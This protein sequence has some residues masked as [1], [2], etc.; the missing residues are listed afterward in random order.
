MPITKNQSGQ[1]AKRRNHTVPKCLLK[2]WLTHLDGSSGH[3]TLDCAGNY[4]FFH[5]GKDAEFAIRDYRYVP[6]RSSQD[7]NAY[8]DESLEDW[9]AQ[10]ENDFA[11]VTDRILAGEQIKASEG[12]FGGFLQAAILLGFRSWYEYTIAEQELKSRRPDLSDE[13]RECMIVDGFKKVYSSKLHQFKNWDY[14]LISKLSEPL[15]LCDRPLFDMT[16]SSPPQ[17]CLFIPLA[18]DLLLIGTAPGDSTRDT[19]IFS[20]TTGS[21]MARRANEMTVE[22]AREFIVG[23][24]AQLIALMPKFTPGKF[25]GRKATDKFRAGVSVPI[26]LKLKPDNV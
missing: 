3:W 25:N 17:D 12:S 7:G 24:E 5:A 22:R 23:T 21:N 20:F 14:M 9:F 19:A 18:P 13:Q 15:L 8:R 10:G 4:V 11:S 2:R 1:N 6:V 16:V 26:P